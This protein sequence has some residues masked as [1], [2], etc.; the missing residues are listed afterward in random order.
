MVIFVP[1]GDPADCSRDSSFYDP[2]F[3][4]LQEC[5]VRILQ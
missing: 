3:Q 2:T 1:E 4:F 5:G